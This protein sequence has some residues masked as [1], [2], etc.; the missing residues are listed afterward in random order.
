M[1]ITIG[2]TADRLQDELEA[3]TKRI[4]SL[5]TK[6][7]ALQSDLDG[8]NTEGYEYF[9]DHVLPKEL[10]RLDELRR[11]KISP[12]DQF[13]Q[14]RIDG[15]QQEIMQL[16]KIKETLELEL[17]GCLIQLFGAKRERDGLQAKLERRLEN[18][19]SRQ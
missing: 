17:R 15:Q 2:K 11:T 13:A 9:K 16:M 1:P 14:C 6:E 12:T 8:Y 18:D 3:L 10:Q 4:S 7:K 5:E 19:A